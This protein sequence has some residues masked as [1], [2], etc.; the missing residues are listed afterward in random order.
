MNEPVVRNEHGAIL[1]ID[2]RR[3]GLVPIGLR[4]PGQVP[5]R[6]VFPGDRVSIAGVEAV[7]HQVQKG[8]VVRLFTRTDKGGQIVF[9]RAA[10]ELVHVSGVGA[11]ER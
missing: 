1:G 10:G 11:F 4:V 6:V 7:V 8:D 3:T 5:A 2:F 9:E